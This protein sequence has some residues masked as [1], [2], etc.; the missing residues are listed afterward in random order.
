MTT[1]LMQAKYGLDATTVGDEG[2][3]APNFQDN[4]EALDLLVE[5]INKAGYEGKIKIGM[6]I[7]ASEF[8]KDGKYDL[9][10]KNPE[11]N[12]EDWLD[13]EALMEMYKGFIENYP[14]VSIEDPFD[15]VQMSS[16]LSYS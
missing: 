8:H 9:D 5:A 2:G 1:F 6:D 12:E 3:F 14:V 11:S 15:Q 10:F 7:A 13:S 16:S 4:K